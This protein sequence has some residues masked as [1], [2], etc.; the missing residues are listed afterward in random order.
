YSTDY[1]LDLSC[2]AMLNPLCT[3]RLATWCDSLDVWRYRKYVQHRRQYT[4]SIGRRT[5]Q[6]VHHVF[7]PWRV[8]HSRFHWCVSG[9]AYAKFAAIHFHPFLFDS[10]STHL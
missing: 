8:E 7:F 9:F 6:E 10:R 5:V 2:C 4:G 1:G 3:E